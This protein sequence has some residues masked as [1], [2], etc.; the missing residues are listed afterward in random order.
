VVIY[1]YVI[2]GNFT[3]GYPQLMV[4][5]YKNVLIYVVIVGGGEGGQTPNLDSRF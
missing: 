2:G 1:G 5:T 3:C 4:L